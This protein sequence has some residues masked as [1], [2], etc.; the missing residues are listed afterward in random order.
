M[1]IRLVCAS[2]KRHNVQIKYYY[3]DFENGTSHHVH[4]HIINYPIQ[5]DK[6]VISYVIFFRSLMHV[7]FISQINM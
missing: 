7:Y 1:S 3:T 6:Q 4:N 2:N 5:L